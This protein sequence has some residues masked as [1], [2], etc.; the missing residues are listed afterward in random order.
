MAQILDYRID[1]GKDSR[2][3]IITADPAAKQN[4]L[5]LQEINKKYEDL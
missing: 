3:E 4:L 2:W 1:M 5:Y